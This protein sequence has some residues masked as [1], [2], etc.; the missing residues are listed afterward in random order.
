MRRPVRPNLRPDLTGVFC[1]LDFANSG[2]HTVGRRIQGEEHGEGIP[3]SGRSQ[4][5]LVPRFPGARPQVHPQPELPTHGCGLSQRRL[6]RSLFLSRPATST[7]NT[8][9]RAGPGRA[10]LIEPFI[11]IGSPWRPTPGFTPADHRQFAD[12]VFDTSCDTWRARHIRDAHLRASK[13]D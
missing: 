1:F 8:T 12:L 3:V 6:G 13:T 11:H 10:V 5:R 9:A 2:Q 4:H 7:A